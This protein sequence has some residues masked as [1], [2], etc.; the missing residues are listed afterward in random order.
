VG[1]TSAIKLADAC[2]LA[3]AYV[4]AGIKNSVQLGTGPGPVAQTGFPSQHDHFPTIATDPA[5]D[6]KGFRPM[7]AHAPGDS[8]DDGIPMLGQILPI[9]DTVDWVQRLVQNTGISDIQLR[10]K[11]V[12]DPDKIVDRVVT[13]QELCEKN[14]VRLW[15]NDHWEAAVHAGCFGVHVGQEDLLRCMDA[16]GLEKL[17][18]NNIALGISTRKYDLVWNAML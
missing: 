6:V 8:N 10:I 13:C 14:G 18:L 3:K 17:R 15:V 2:C 1:A 11:D 5:S 9:V 12:T 4:S 7:K 16:G